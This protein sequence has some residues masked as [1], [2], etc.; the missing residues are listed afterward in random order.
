MNFFQSETK[1][2]SKQE[3]KYIEF[4]S[5][6]LFNCPTIGL[7]ESQ[8]IVDLMEQINDYIQTNFAEDL[9]LMSVMTIINCNYS[10]DESH[11]QKIKQCISTLDKIVTNLAESNAEDR[12]KFKK[13]RKAKIANRVLE[14]NGGLEFL[15][16]IGFEL[17]SEEEWF[18]FRGDEDGIS[19]QMNYY[20]DVLNNVQQFPI[21]LDRQQVL[22]QT[23]QTLNDK[24]LSDDF[25]KL[26]TDELSQQ[27]RNLTEK[28][29]L[30]ETLRTRA[31]REQ[32]QKRPNCK[33]SRLRFKLPSGLQMD[34]TF[35]SNE[36]LSDVKNWLLQHLDSIDFNMKCGPDLFSDAH[37]SKTIN[38]LNL[39]PTA[40]LLIISKE[41]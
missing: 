18:V 29:E 27:M 16:S 15:I 26:S 7:N 14:L 9:T 41:N 35:K 6:Q 21:I 11:E 25:F 34:A 23:N 33:F 1:E 20:K 38:E 17:D 22:V 24:N 5:K 32:K 8:P 13:I 39:V 3:K 2:E 12:D 36:T 10:I 4:E 28:R 31:M 19:D 37:L 30:E 40:A